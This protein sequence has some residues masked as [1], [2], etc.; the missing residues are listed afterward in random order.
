MKTFRHISK[1]MK[2]ARLDAQISQ[3]ELAAHLGYISPQMI[4]NWE[5][6][7]CGPPMDA[8]KASIKYLNVNKAQIKAAL[9]KDY[10]ADL[11]EGLRG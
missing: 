1:I 2:R 3:K 7:L 10:E 4:S 5:R 8:V 9:I 6:E 11:D